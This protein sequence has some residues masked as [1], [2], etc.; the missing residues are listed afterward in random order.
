MVDLG[1]STCRNI[2]AVVGVLYLSNVAL[3]R[4]HK[5]AGGLRAY[6]LA[7]LGISRTNLRKYGKWAGELQVAVAT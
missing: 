5:L 3:R 2:A 7:P 1:P 4:L 6:F